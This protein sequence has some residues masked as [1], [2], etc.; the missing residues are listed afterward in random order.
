MS[1]RTALRDTSGKPISRDQARIKLLET[2]WDQDAGGLW[3]D[4]FAPH[5]RAPAFTLRD[6]WE[7]HVA[8]SSLYAAFRR[9]GT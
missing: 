9:K 5:E 2:G 4:S 3:I 8:L 1:E 6:A 7:R